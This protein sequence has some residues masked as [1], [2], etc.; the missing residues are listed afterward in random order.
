MRA[1]RVRA[2]TG[3]VGVPNLESLAPVQ[4]SP[5]IPAS[6]DLDREPLSG[7]GTPSPSSQHESC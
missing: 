7:L 6:G 1:L 5:N 4:D 3:R 2:P